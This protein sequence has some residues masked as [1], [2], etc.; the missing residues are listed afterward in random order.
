MDP[1]DD[2]AFPLRSIDA[3]CV[4]GVDPAH[5]GSVCVDDGFGLLRRAPIAR[6]GA[7]RE[8]SGGHAERGFGFLEGGSDQRTATEHA[9]GRSGG[10]DVD[11]RGSDS[12]WFDR[13]RLPHVRTQPHRGR[14]RG[15]SLTVAVRVLRTA[16]CEPLNWFGFANDQGRGHPAGRGTAA[17]RG[18]ATLHSAD[19][20][21]NA[22]HNRT[23]GQ[24]AVG[25]R[26]ARC[27]IPS[28]SAI[29][30]RR[31]IGASTGLIATSMA[32]SRASRVT[33]VRRRARRTASTSRRASP[34][35]RI[36][37]RYP[38][39]FDLD[40]LRLHFAACARRPAPSMRSS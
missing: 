6:L 9:A 22:D 34:L 1:L 30:T 27:N 2:S 35:G 8:S 36:G 21:G 26:P 38:V 14:S 19:S 11:R 25:Q 28:S 7:C 18:G 20:R 37:K 39:K 16:F 10:V 3:P 17:Q 15:R 12:E 29:C 31:I 13:F 4:E 5:A 23:Y 33:C 40:E 32:A 24:D